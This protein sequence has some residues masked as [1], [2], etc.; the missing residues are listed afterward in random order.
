MQPPSVSDSLGD[1]PLSVSDSETDLLLR[2][3]KVGRL[4]Q[5]GMTI[6]EICDE[7]NLSEKTVCADIRAVCR[8]WLG[9]IALNHNVWVA[10]SLE[11][12]E[13]AEQEAWQGYYR[14]IGPDK[15]TMVETSDDGV[16]RRVTKRQ[17]YG[18]P[19]FL[20]IVLNIQRQRAV[21]LGLMTK[22]QANEVGRFNVKKPKMLII[23]DRQQ[24]QDLIDVSAIGTSQVV[25]VKLK[26]DEEAET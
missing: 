25:D 10:E 16:K 13:T 19:R 3:A 11:K 14:S 12:L 6:K 22:T 2:R 18:D 1:N 26:D 5:K 9:R 21:L 7:L 17:R 20:Q 24:A 8:H 23:K 15:E 4:R